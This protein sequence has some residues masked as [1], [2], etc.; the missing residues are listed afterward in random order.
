MLPIFKTHSSIGKSILTFDLPNENSEKTSIFD[1]GLKQICVVEDN[2]SQLPKLFENSKKL[3][4][5]LLFGLSLFICNEEEYSKTDCNIKSKIILFAKNK[6]GIK[7]L[8]KVFSKSKEQDK[9]FITNEKL[10][11]FFDENLLQLCLPFYDSF[12]HKNKFTFSF[13]APPNLNDFGKPIFF[14]EDNNVS[15]DKL[16]QGVV[17]DYC[18]KNNFNYIKTKSIY[19][20]KREDIESFAA[21]KLLTNRSFGSVSLEKPNLD[22]FSSKEF[23]WESYCDVNK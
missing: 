22:H 6:D 14:L 17:L 5:N 2:L 23:S 16:L 20:N 15:Y 1:F 3:N 11:E 21:Y 13:C 10:K 18:S 7:L 4:V 19:Y 8:N 12:L 9:N